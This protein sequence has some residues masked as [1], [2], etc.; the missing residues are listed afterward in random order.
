MDR[1]FKTDIRHK[2]ETNFRHPTPGFE[3][4]KVVRVSHE[5]WGPAYHACRGSR[6]V[7]IV[8][9]IIRGKGYFHGV[10]GHTALKSGMVYTRCPGSELTY[11]CDPKDPLELQMVSATGQGVASLF[12]ECIEK[13]NSAF[14]VTNA[15]AVA[16]TMQSLFEQAVNRPTM[17]GRICRRYF[18]ILLMQLKQGTVELD[19]PDSRA[20]Q[21]YLAARQLIYDKAYAMRSAGEVAQQL[22]ITSAHLSRLFRRF[23]DESPLAC[24]QRM[25]M[26]RAAHLLS[27]TPMTIKE[28]AE[29]L[30]SPDQF[31]FS[32]QFK[33][34]HAVSPQQ[35]RAS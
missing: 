21:T 22:G 10:N 26:N 11:G 2:T 19:A 9:Y 32:R 25:R 6:D 3:G 35:Y 4:V 20:H 12:E 23:G 14:A 8:A 34:W 5:H 17:S 28:I 15:H 30:N 18:E 27:T 31:T 29:A 16:Q 33:K 13:P 24:L 1:P 7:W